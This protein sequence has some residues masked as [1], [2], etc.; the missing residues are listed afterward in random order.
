MKICLIQPYDA[1]RHYYAMIPS[2]GLA[3]LAALCGRDGHSVRIIDALAHRLSPG[4]IADLARRERPDVAGVTFFTPD[5][6]AVR[7]TVRELA[8]A[9]HEIRLDDRADK[10]TERAE[11]ILAAFQHTLL[12]DGVL[13]GMAYF[14]SGTPRF[15]LHPRDEET[16]IHYSVLAMIHAIL[17]DMFTPEQAAEHLALIEKYL[18][19]PDG[20]RLFD[21]PLAYRGG[22]MTNFQRAET[23]SYFGREIGIMYTHAHLRF[24]EALAHIGDADLPIL[25]GPGRKAE[26]AFDVGQQA[27]AAGVVGVLA[28]DLD[29]AGDEPVPRCLNA[30]GKGGGTAV[31][32][33]GKAGGRRRG[34]ASRQELLR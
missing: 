32:V 24:A 12:S 30:R 19:G 15:M 2:A 22:V 25:A 31:E 14:E 5:H 3:S 20:V 27:L 6:A 16:G 18:T 23:A 7:E 21:K 8:E 9:F 34:Q 26:A 4:R 29:P 11:R 13:A 17:S 1:R 28:H 33:L 10:L